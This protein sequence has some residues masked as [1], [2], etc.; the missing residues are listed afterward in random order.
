MTVAALPFDRPL[1][2]VPAIAHVELSLW[3]QILLVL[4]A[5]LVLAT[6]IEVVGEWVAGAWGE[7]GTIRTVFFEEVTLPLY[8]SVFLYGVLV[9]V[10]LLEVEVMIGVAENVLFTVML[11]LWARGGIRFGN[12][13]LDLVKQQDRSYEFAPV[14]K[15]IWSV[16][17]VT[18][19]FIGLLVVWEIDITPLLASAGLLGIV[20]GF[21]ARDAVANFIGGIALF[22]DDTYKLGDF[23]VLESGEKGTV[24]DIGLRSTTL[25]TRDRVMVTVPN[26]VLNTSQVVNE[27]APQRYKRIRLP[28]RVAYGVDTD[29]VEE[30][31]MEAAEGA[32]EVRETPSPEVRLDQFGDDGIDYELRVF[33]PHPTR[34]ARARHEVNTAVYRRFAAENIEIPYP[35]RDVRM[36]DR[37]RDGVPEPL[38]SGSGGMDPGGEDP[39]GDGPGGDGPTRQ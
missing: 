18:A 37:P 32:S 20:L 28:I 4:A 11:V 30:L 5:S 39:G 24:V 9:S 17:V 8:A 29:R 12:R 3:V 6:L 1:P 23:I 15:N 13:S 31:L 26:S 35:Q 33:I 34:E 16:F 10:R 27:S 22:F 7:G 2:L 25:L 19:A 36:R 14:F 38:E 21:A